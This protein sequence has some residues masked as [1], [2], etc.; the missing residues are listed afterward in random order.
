MLS[1]WWG[2]MAGAALVSQCVLFWTNPELTVPPIYWIMG[3]VAFVG[4]IWLWW[5]SEVSDA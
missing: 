4:H 5:T 1:Y 3:A 2:I